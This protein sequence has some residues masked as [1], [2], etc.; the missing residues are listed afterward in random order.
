MLVTE[1]LKKKPKL[2]SLDTL[3]IKTYG[4]AMNVYDSSRMSDLMQEAYGLRVVDEPQDADVILMNTC[5][6]RENAENKVYSEL[7]RY[8]KIKDKRPD[9]IIGV[10]GCVGQQEGDRIQKRAPYVDIVFG[11]Q[12]YHRLP[13]MVKE[14]RRGRV[15]LSETD[16]PEIEK[17]D[18]LPKPKVEG[19]TGYVTIM[20]GCDK[21][22]TFCIVPYTRGAE[23]SRPPAD[24]LKECGQL[25]EAGAK[26]ISLLG[27]NVNA[28]HCENTDGEDVGFAE[29]LHLVGELQGMQRLRFS[30][31][32]PMEM[33]TELC[34]A[35]A[36]IPALM[37]Y[38]HLPVQSGSNEILK[39]MHRGHN[40]EDYFKAIDELRSFTP[41]IAL[42]SDFIVGFPG[43]TD[44][45]FEQTLA[46]VRK[47]GY[48]SAFCFKYSPRPGT[49]A[50]KADDNVSESVK[51]ERLQRLL[52][53]LREQSRARMEQQVGKN[54]EVLIESK[55]RNEGDL[56][57]RTP[58]FRI[59]HFKGN[60]R[61]IGQ[62]LPVKITAAYNMS[63]RGELIIE[64]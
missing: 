59:V 22:C 4:C 7:G 13:D 51:D 64:D 41:D 11:P 14:I 42:S 16:M 18:H 3:F 8:K 32:H 5:S 29:L 19:L 28:Y 55:S 20:E 44:E 1:K 6:I 49:P 15:N 34:E 2:K 58:D 48:D 24:I 63:L 31:S 53:L 61:L 47:V 39:A 33:T 30:T 62:T 45:D 17:F 37:P 40:R 35:F 36:D 26:D 43:E 57:G 10:G 56:Q 60:V 23:I 54:T 46:L 9:L 52:G 50:S 25:I 27:Q 21:F 12:T 38:L